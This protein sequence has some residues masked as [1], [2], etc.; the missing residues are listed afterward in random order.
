MT[1]MMVAIDMVMP[2]NISRAW[3]GT[4]AGTRA[5]TG[6]RASAGAGAGSIT[7]ARTGAGTR[8][9]TGAGTRA[10]TGARTRARAG[11]SGTSRAYW[12][13]ASFAIAAKIL[14]VVRDAT[15]IGNSSTKLSVLTEDVGTMARG[16]H[17][18]FD[19]GF[20]IRITVGYVLSYRGPLEANCSDTVAWGSFTRSLVSHL[21]RI[22]LRI[23][24]VLRSFG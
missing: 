15:T 2:D 21:T 8:A 14:S 22:R 1:A 10:R 24:V 7:R 19:A 16:C 3:A 13:V 6:T 20:L 17:P 9:R 4:R 12:I 18:F 11:S 23:A 5:W